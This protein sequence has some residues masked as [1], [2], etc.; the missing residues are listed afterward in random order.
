MRSWLPHQLLAPILKRMEWIVSPHQEVLYPATRQLLNSQGYVGCDGG[1]ADADCLA[2]VT[3]FMDHSAPGFAQ[4]RERLDVLLA[5]YPLCDESLGRSGEKVRAWVR[6]EIIYPTMWKYSVDDVAQFAFER[7]NNVGEMLR[8]SDDLHINLEPLPWPGR[9]QASIASNGNHRT[10]VYQALGLPLIPAQVC[11]PSSQWVVNGS[12]FP[13]LEEME[14]RGLV[15]ILNTDSGGV[16]F[17]DPTG[18]AHWLMPLST[19]GAPPRFSMSRN[20]RST[21]LPP[22]PADVLLRIHQIEEYGGERLPDARFDFL[23]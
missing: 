20:P 5:R 4:V 21:I 13:I 22:D 1:Q 14:R 9:Y 19:I 16:I 17:T 7:A 11:V 23:R 3:R 10:L 6:P 8:A 15:Q 12:L 18:I 2:L